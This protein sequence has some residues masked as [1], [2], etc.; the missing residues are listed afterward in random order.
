MVKSNGL[1]IIIP[2]PVCEHDMLQSTGIHVCTGKV[3]CQKCSNF[4]YVADLYAFKSLGKEKC[5]KII[6]EHQLR[7]DLETNPRAVE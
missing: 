7:L 2:C 1:I 4:F 5:I 6:D 3:K